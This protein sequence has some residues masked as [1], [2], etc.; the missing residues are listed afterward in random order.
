M[1]SLGIQKQLLCFATLLFLVLMQTQVLCYQY[2]VGDLS[3]WGIP[4]SSNK[5][6]YSKWSKKY[7][8]KIGDSLLFL[9]P[10]SEDSVVQVTEEA[11]NSCNITDPILYMNNGNSLFNITSVDNYYFTSGQKGHCEKYQKLKISM[12]SGSGPSS[13]P[14]YGPAASPSYEN[15]FGSIPA[16]PSSS[17]SINIPVFLSVAIGFLSALV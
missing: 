11:Y 8:L 3:A 16:P 14:P 15:V 1:G 12:L 17:S 10:P 2:K 13:A 9:Y 4:T 6:V 5:N 7:S